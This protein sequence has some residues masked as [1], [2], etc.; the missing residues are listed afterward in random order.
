MSRLRIGSMAT[1]P[2]RKDII[3]KVVASI[4]PQVDSLQIKRGDN[5]LG[6]ANKFWR[7][8]QMEGYIFICDDDLLYPSDYADVMVSKVE[9]YNRKAVIGLHGRTFHTQP[10]RSYYKSPFDCIRAL[11]RNG[12][13]QFV[14]IIATCALCFHSD[15]IEISMEDFKA[16]NMADIWFSIACENQG[17]MR[18]AIEHE[19]GWIGYLNPD[20]TIYEEYKKDHKTQTDA[21]NSI[22]WNL[23]DTTD[24]PFKQ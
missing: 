22:R 9:Q 13:D 24:Y 11:D 23:P 10:I 2:K 1:I 12:A 18:V 3:G 6:D 7:V 4:I 14:Q 15:T 5:D 20:W 19:E 8:D 17:I 21:V 16:A